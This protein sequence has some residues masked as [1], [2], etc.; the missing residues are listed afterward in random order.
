MEEEN[1][2]NCRVD[3]GDGG[4][5]VWVLN[6][7]FKNEFGTPDPSKSIW[8]NDYHTIINR[9]LECWEEIG[10]KPTLFAIDF[11][12]EG[13]LVNATISLNQ[14]SHWTDQVPERS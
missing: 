12:E 14:M 2:M 4:Q 10:N 13:E 1:D 11:W 3:R 5:T 7:F 9:T 8:A 6:H